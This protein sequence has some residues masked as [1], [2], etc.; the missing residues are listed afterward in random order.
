MVKVK[1]RD[2]AT[3]AKK[4]VEE[5]PKRA[6][7]YEAGVKTPKEDWAIEAIAAAPVYKA[8]VSA[9]NIDKLFSGGVKRAGTAK[10]QKKAIDLGVTRFGPGVSAAETDYSSG[11]GP[12]RDEIERVDL[13]ERGPRGSDGNWERSKKLGKA[14][15]I[16]RLALKAAGS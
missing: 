7:Y 8:A 9:A 4:W 13:P 6:S 14:L 15:N 10:W 12:F 11:F 16:K 3:I 2:L 5:T 1:V